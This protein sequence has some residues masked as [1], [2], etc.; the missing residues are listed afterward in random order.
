MLLT[1]AVMA[2]STSFHCAPPFQ[3]TGVIVCIRFVELVFP[4]FNGRHI[5]EQLAREQSVF[6]RW[7]K[8]LDLCRRAA[9]KHAEERDVTFAV[10]VIGAPVVGQPVMVETFPEE[11][12]PVSVI[13]SNGGAHGVGLGFAYQSYASGVHQVFLYACT[14][15]V[16]GYEEHFQLGLFG[17]GGICL[18]LPQSV[19]FGLFHAVGLYFFPVGVQQRVVYGFCQTAYPGQRTFAGSGR[20]G[21]EYLQTGILVLSSVHKTYQFVE[22]ASQHGC[23][24]QQQDIPLGGR[25]TAVYDSLQEGGPA[26]VGERGKSGREDGLGHAVGQGG[27]WVR[28]NGIGRSPVGSIRMGIIGYARTCVGVE[29]LQVLQ[30]CKFRVH[31]HPGHLCQ[32]EDGSQ[33][34]S[35]C[36]F[37]QSMSVQFVCFIVV[38]LFGYAADAVEPGASFLAASVG[39]GKGQRHIFLIGG[40]HID[41]RLF[42]GCY[43]LFQDR[44]RIVHFLIFM[45][46]DF[47]FSVVRQKTSSGQVGIGPV[48]F[49]LVFPFQILPC[50]VQGIVEGFFYAQERVY[51]VRDKQFYSLIS[52]ADKG[53]YGVQHFIGKETVAPHCR[54]FGGSQFVNIYDKEARRNLHTL[55]FAVREDTC[56]SDI[57]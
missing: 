47:R 54:F 10:F 56:R 2:S 13:A 42:D 45:V 57:R 32:M 44:N 52:G 46:I 38:V 33:G 34:I 5:V 21:D 26:V 22:G 19:P 4:F 49:Q 24:T 16:A 9:E 1:E 20:R 39:Y 40:G 12:A 6:G 36:S 17:F 53:K 11:V 28:E 29:R 43:Q 37:G 14:G 31:F 55:L 41:S 48:H 7:D 23:R 30:V 50:G 8:G 35:A 18:F 3:E 15:I 25:V 51:A 27:G